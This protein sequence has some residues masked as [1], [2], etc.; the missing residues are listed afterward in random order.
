MNYISLIILRT[1]LVVIRTATVTSS[2]SAVSTLFQCHLSLC[3]CRLQ[4]SCCVTF[5]PVS[6]SL[7]QQAGD[8]F[9]SFLPGIAV[10]LCRVITG[11]VTQ[12]HAVTKVCHTHWW[13]PVAISGDITEQV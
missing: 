4:S 13:L 5:V 10:S 1:F 9:A 2:V 11:E 8:S 6:P 3:Q 7:T 12:G